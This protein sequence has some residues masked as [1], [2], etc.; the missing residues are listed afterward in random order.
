MKVEVRRKG[1]SRRWV[2]EEDEVIRH[3][4]EDEVVRG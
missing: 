4:D 1:Y 2:D 3:E